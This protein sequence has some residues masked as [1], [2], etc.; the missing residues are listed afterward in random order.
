MPSSHVL[1]STWCTGPVYVCGMH[2]YRLCALCL[3]SCFNSQFLCCACVYFGVL[4][5][6]LPHVLHVPLAQTHPHNVMH[7][8]STLC[9]QSLCVYVVHT[10]HSGTLKTG[11]SV[12]QKCVECLEMA[13]LIPNLC[14]GGTTLEMEKTM[15][16]RLHTIQANNIYGDCTLSLIM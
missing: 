2:I 15:S 12:Q 3:L 13:Y 7:L 4:C 14:P 8:S 16:Y 6:Q 5:M 11:S 9:K 10:L 1:Q